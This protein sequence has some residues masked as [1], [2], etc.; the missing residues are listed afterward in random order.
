VESVRASCTFFEGEITG[1]EE[2]RGDE[3]RRRVRRKEE[4]EEVS[5]VGWREAK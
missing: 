3:K 4:V 1:S 5:R 2:G